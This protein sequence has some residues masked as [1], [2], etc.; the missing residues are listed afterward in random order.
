M[1]ERFRCAAIEIPSDKQILFENQL[2]IVFIGDDNSI[3]VQTGTKGFCFAAKKIV[4]QGN[5]IIIQSHTNEKYIFAK[6]NQD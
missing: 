1:V 4:N 3:E 5:S 6:A 2:C